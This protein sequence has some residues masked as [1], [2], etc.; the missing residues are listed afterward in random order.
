MRDD[1]WA[2]GKSGLEATGRC[3]RHRVAGT[4]MPMLSTAQCSRVLEHVA[5]TSAE[6]RETHPPIQCNDTFTWAQDLDGIEVEL[7]QFGDALH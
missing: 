3:H 1:S 7:L 4:I 6:R 5:D 2:E